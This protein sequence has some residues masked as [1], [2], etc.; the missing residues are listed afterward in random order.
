[1]DYQ[2]T[3]A[4]DGG[5][6]HHADAW[7]HAAFDGSAGA[8]ALWRG[9]LQLRLRSAADRIAGWRVEERTPQ[10]LVVAA[11]SWHLRA[12]LTWAAYADGVEVTTHVTSRNAAGA[13]A[14]TTLS[15]VHRAAVPGVLER[16]RRRLRA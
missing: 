16:A 12:W 1:M 3:F 9:V 5:G 8:Q 7:M 11:E 4:V 10:R 2:D 13:V 14:W 15:P 6:R